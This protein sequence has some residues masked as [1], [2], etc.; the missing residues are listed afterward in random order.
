MRVRRTPLLLGALLLAGALLSAIPA[1][2]ATL[3]LS[4]LCG[5]AS[6]ITSPG[7]GVKVATDGV[8]NRAGAAWSSPISTLGNFTLTFDYSISGSGASRYHADGFAVVVQTTSATALG[9]W[10]GSL[11]YAGTTTEAGCTSIGTRKSSFAVGFNDYG[12]TIR[13]G[14]DGSWT[15]NLQTNAKV[16]G[17]HS[18]VISKAGATVTV[19]LDGRTVGSFSTGTASYSRAF[20]G[21]T[22]STGTYTEDILI[23]DIALTQS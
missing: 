1:S 13:R 17:R 23:H 6:R 3:G 19:V 10:G 20:V 14:V 2:A 18:V 21:F 12:D 4:T 9:F 16:S 8:V 15:G 11:A 5:N 22:G 7:V